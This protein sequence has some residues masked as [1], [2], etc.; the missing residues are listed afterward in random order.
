MSR[1]PG[2][3]GALGLG[4]AE[5]TSLLEAGGIGR[6]FTPAVHPQLG[7]EMG[8]IVPD[9]LF[10]QKEPLRDLTVREAPGDE[11]EDM[12]LLLRK[13]EDKWIR[14]DS[15]PHLREERIRQDR[16]QG[17]STL[18][19]LPDRLDQV[20]TRPLLEHVARRSGEDGGGDVTLV[21]EG[22]QDEAAHFRMA[23]SDLSAEF[24]A[25]PFDELDVHDGDVGP[26]G[27]NPGEGLAGG[28]GLAHD[29]KIGFVRDERPESDAQELVIVDKED[30]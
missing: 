10:G 9:G 25:V 19:D 8:D 13:A 7:E 20:A 2:V 6:R 21:A 14:L 3:T 23:G 11:F 29:E 18:A 4:A 28:P 16:I 17:R 26:L 12:P 30:A 5:L 15:G 27:G 1:S 22:A 24:D